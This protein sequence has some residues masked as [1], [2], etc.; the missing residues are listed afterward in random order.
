MLIVDTR[1]PEGMR[2]DCDAVYDLK[3]MLGVGDFLIIVNKENPDGTS[4]E[5]RLIVERKTA[6]DFIN[7]TYMEGRL[8]MQL[9]GVDALIFE[10]MFVPRRPAGWWMNLHTTL[11]G[12]AHHTPVFY[13]LS[14]KHTIKQL[15][16]FEEK[17]K[18]GEWG[19]M[20]RPIVIPPVTAEENESQVRCIM[21]FPG[22]GEKRANDILK[23]YGTLENALKSIESWS[24]D[25]K[26]IGGKTL[27][28]SLKVYRGEVK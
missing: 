11:N 1:E 26:G 24:K 18:K 17:M 13:T 23:K 4:T 7:T 10:R 20:R 28:A 19:K 21:A 6:G 9:D 2:K 14:S 12:V 27:E 16:I 8:N 3:K 25:V 22:V 5:Q 15:R